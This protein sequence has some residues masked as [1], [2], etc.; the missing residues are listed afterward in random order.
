MKPAE[1]ERWKNA[2]L[3]FARKLTLKDRRP[4]GSSKRLLIKSP[5]HTYRIP[6]LLEMFPKA[7]FLF[8]SRNPYSVYSSTLHLR[9]TMFVENGL[10][11]N[12][13]SGLEEMTLKVYRD[14]FNCYERDRHLIPEGQLCEMR[15]EDLESNPLQELER[16]YQW[17]DL[18]DLE[19][20]RVGAQKELE[21]RERYRKNS[22][23]LDAET[24][25]RVYHEWQ[26][27]FQRFGY[28]SDIKSTGVKTA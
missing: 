10:G 11:L 15:F 12:D 3:T 16:V 4:D 25:E 18:P 20:L 6:L 22:Y 8:I 2:F 5:T 28:D 13:F 19:Q 26:A 27:A 23:R 14:L 9:R 24:M 21:G 7:K 17:I 1:R